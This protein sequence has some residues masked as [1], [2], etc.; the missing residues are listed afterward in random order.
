MKVEQLPTIN[1][2]KAFEPVVLKI[3]IET[4]QELADLH[5][6]LISKLGGHEFFV[7]VNRICKGLV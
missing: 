7:V 1:F 3:T 4:R 6:M 5:Y 2:P